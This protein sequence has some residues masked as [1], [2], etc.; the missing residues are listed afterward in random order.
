MTEKRF[1]PLEIREGQDLG[2]V[3]GVAVRYGDTARIPTPAGTF[4]ERIY[5]SAFGDLGNVD[6]ILNVMHDRQR[7]VARTGG[8]GLALS[9][10]Q[11]ALTLEAQ[12]PDTQDGRDARVLLSRRILRGLSVEMLVKKDSVDPGSRLRTI[13][14][15]DLVG[16]GLVDR[17]AYGDS[18]A[19]LKRFETRAEDYDYEGEYEYENDEF[20]S[21]EGGIYKRRIRPGAFTNSIKD[22]AQ[23]IT[24]S[25]GRNP[26][27]ASVLG[28]KLNETLDLLDDD[29][30]LRVRLRQAP[31]TQAW[32]DL[33]AQADAGMAL[34]LTPLIRALANGDG[35][36]IIDERQDRPQ[37]KVRVYSNLTLY[38][39]SLAV[40]QPKGAHSKGEV[41]Q[42]WQLEIP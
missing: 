28:S 1:M 23:E 42:S 5:P 3:K 6:A 34:Y 39:L 2:L 9:N 33:K 22:A 35:V 16:I 27:G 31:D 29:D 4:H 11:Q 30:A 18:Q 17:P 32:R 8:G 15:A 10:T 36:E 40:R 24:L 37:A 25:V 13:H 41:R 12:L 38:G 19:V 26:T 21:S 7:P 14:Q 20:D